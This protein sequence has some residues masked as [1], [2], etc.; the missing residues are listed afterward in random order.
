[1]TP[2][3]GDKN[4][5]NKQGDKYYMAM[6]VLSLILFD[7]D[8]WKLSL[9]TEGMVKIFLKVT[10]SLANNNINNE[11]ISK[12]YTPMVPLLIIMFDYYLLMMLI[13][14]DAIQEWVL[15]FIVPVIEKCANKICTILYI[16]KIPT[17]NIR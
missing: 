5:D 10:L 15:N 12:D 17:Y 8:V 3:L 13:F 4:N 16:R 1:M 14:S 6:V 2:S 7:A 9:L 11:Y